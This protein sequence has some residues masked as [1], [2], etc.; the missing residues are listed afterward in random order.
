MPLTNV[1]FWA[2]WNNNNDA[3][4][5]GLGC[6]VKG[7]ERVVFF[8]LIVDFVGR[9]AVMFPTSAVP[10]RTTTTQHHTPAPLHA[11]GTAL[12]S[13]DGLEVTEEIYSAS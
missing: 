12:V 3:C 10:T 4:A 7:A 13:C 2:L 11:T 9:K 8:R 1:F 5:F 6:D